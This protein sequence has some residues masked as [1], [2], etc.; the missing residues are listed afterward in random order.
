MLKS[1]G[2]DLW[3]D[4][5]DQSVG[6]SDAQDTYPFAGYRQVLDTIYGR[7]RQDG[8]IHRIADVG[9]GTAVLAR[10]LYGD[11]YAI[12]GL[13]FSPRMLEIARERMPRAALLCHD[14]TEGFP[15]AWADHRFDCII[16]TYALHHLTD[17]QKAD[18]LAQCL[19]HA[20]LVLIGDVAFPDS[21]AQ[22]ACRRLAGEE[23][24]DDEH[25]FVVDRQAFPT[26][27]TVAFE[28]CSH[29]AGVIELAR[30]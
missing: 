20:P 23:W 29:C 4:G 7:I 10:R 16:S 12:S 21:A 25:Y 24:D 26:D 8:R 15:A 3:A 1:D 28:P 18:F 2:F 27:A 13:D 30:K 5:Y 14:L 22:E 6:L 9:V 19:L 17:G 11:G